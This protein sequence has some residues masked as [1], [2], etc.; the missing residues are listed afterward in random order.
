MNYGLVIRRLRRLNG[1]NLREAAKKMNK[2]P[3]WLSEIEN[4]KGKSRLSKDEFDCIVHLF[5]G[6]RHRKHFYRWTGKELKKSK[7]KNETIFDGAVFRHLRNKKQLNLKQAAVALGLSKSQL[8]NIET[9]RR[10][11]DEDR[12]A[13]IM[14]LYGY[15]RESFKNFSTNDKRGSSIPSQYKLDIVLRLLSEEIKAKVLDFAIGLH[16]AGGANE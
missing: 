1:L 12:K 10:T 8:S 13:K 14:A 3:G 7:S 4:Q 6:D 16:N 5:N 2:S 11:V 9:G 15:K